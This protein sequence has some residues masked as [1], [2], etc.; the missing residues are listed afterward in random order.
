MYL[1]SPSYNV[2]VRAKTNHCCVSYQVCTNDMMAFTLNANT[3]VTAI[4]QGP[5]LIGPS[6]L[7]DYIKI[8]GATSQGGPESPTS[9]YCGDT[10]NPVAMST[11]NVPIRGALIECRAQNIKL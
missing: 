5:A 2:C 8:S 4:S 7:L 11:T 6:C 1:K 9:R 10:L 3:P